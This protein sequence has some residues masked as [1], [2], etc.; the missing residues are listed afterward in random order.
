LTAAMR[1]NM[2]IAARF[3]GAG[4][5]SSIAGL[6]MAI[7]AR[8]AGSGNLST[9]ANLA[10]ALAARLD[11]S[12]DLSI[13]ANVI[14]AGTHLISATFSGEGGLRVDMQKFGPRHTQ[15]IRDVKAA[16]E[17]RRSPVFESRANPAKQKRT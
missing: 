2:V 17:S 7:A 11:G 1:A 4:S 15:S 12:G 14:P 13:A 5:L 6:G 16:F 9:F 3:D 10:L 8:F